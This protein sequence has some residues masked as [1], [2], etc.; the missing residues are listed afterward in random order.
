MIERVKRWLAG[1]GMDRESRVGQ[2]ERPHVRWL[3]NLHVFFLVR[4]VFR[5][6]SACQ[7]SKEEALDTVRK[8]DA[9]SEN[10]RKIDRKWTETQRNA[11]HARTHACTIRVTKRY[12][13][14]C[15][16]DRFGYQNGPKIAPGALRSAFGALGGISGRSRDAPGTPRDSLGTPRGAPGMLPGRPR[17]SQG[18]PRSVQ[19]ATREC[20]RCVGS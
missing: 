10:R 13:N 18:G 6:R 7:P 11:A 14:R 8:P 4:F 3:R 19:R 1:H 17:D 15:Q 12:E 5:S 2:L 9:M 16:T 20:P